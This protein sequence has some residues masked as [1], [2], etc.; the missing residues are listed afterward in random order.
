MIVAHNKKPLRELIPQEIARQGN[1]ADLNHIDVLQITA[2]SNLFNDEFREF[3]VDIR[4]L[5]YRQ[6]EEYGKDVS[7]FAV[8]RRYF[9]LEYLDMSKTWVGCFKIHSLT[10]IFQTGIPGNVTNMSLM[11]SGSQF[12]GDISGWNT[13]N[14]TNMN[15]M[16]SR[17][18]FNRDI[19]GW[20]TG[21]VTDMSEMFYMS[22]FNGD[23]SNWDTGNVTDMGMMFYELKFNGDISKWNTGN[24]TNMNHMF[25]YSQN[26]TV[27]FLSGTLV[28]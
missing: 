20:N 9:R 6:C 25:Y 13:G 18:Q 5:E 4:G 10:A 19:S 7:R 21:N 17:S 11:F 24:V 28:M 2:M 12:N 15:S 22:Q 16:F 23:I 27:I 26:L 8:Q 3:N 14:V 1:N